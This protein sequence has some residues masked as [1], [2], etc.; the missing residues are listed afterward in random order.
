MRR[1][2]FRDDGYAVV[3]ISGKFGVINSEGKYVINPR[4]DAIGNASEN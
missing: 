3:K 1:E 2:S 4:F